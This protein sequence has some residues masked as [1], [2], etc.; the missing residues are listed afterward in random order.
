MATGIVM[1]TVGLGVLVASAWT[2][3]PSLALFLIGG[4]LVGGGVGGIFRGS[5]GVVL[6]ASGP[7][8]RA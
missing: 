5:L 3:P 2:A 1:I 7:E 6:S 4:A 8:D